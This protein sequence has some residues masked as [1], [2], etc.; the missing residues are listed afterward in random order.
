MFKK[1]LPFFY[2]LSLGAM[3]Q[4]THNPGKIDYISRLP[5][6]I[7]C[8]IGQK[9]LTFRDNIND[10]MEKNEFGQRH[11]LGVSFFDDEYYPEEERIIDEPKK[12]GVGKIV[13]FFKH[14][15]SRKDN[16]LDDIIEIHGKK[17]NENALN[18]LMHWELDFPA[19]FRSIDGI[20]QIVNIK[21]FGRVNKHMHS[22]VSDMLRGEASKF[23]VPYAIKTIAHN[24]AV[25]E[26]NDE[27]RF[28]QVY[29]AAHIDETREAKYFDAFLKELLLP[30]KNKIILNDQEK[31]QKAMQPAD[32]LYAI[33]GR[34]RY[35]IELKNST[36]DYGPA[37]Y[38]QY[39]KLYPQRIRQA[40]IENK[41]NID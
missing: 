27:E 22:L 1:L 37:H 20:Q 11:L 33:F 23:F 18:K 38:S 16:K 9:L 31:S 39:L 4:S 21:N 32:M 36:M 13:A 34:G 19:Q 8:L 30:E 6:E 14:K 24:M 2:V 15:G 41:F 12:K 26:H 17:F 35:A 10:G 25:I 5:D 40:L 3:E 29:V 7:Q 28:L